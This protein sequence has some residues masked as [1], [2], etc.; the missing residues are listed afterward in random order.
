MKSAAILTLSLLIAAPAAVTFAPASAEA[1]VLAGSNA[2]R[3][4][5]PRR[6]GLSERDRQRLFEA[7][8]NLVENEDAIAELNAITEAG[9]VL[10][11]R[12]SRELAE[13]QR[14]LADAQRTIERLEAK[15]ERLGG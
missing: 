12:Q 14:R 7:Q 4:A 3:R 10:N 13:R 6:P 1:Q 11:E 15:N 2:A 8:D 5:A 9:G